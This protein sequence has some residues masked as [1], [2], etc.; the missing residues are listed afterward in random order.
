MSARRWITQPIAFIANALIALAGLFLLGG[1]L[2]F[3]QLVD[4]GPMQ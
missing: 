4:G 1:L 2:A 3:E